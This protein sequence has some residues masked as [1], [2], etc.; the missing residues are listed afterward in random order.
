[1]TI[2]GELSHVNFKKQV[3]VSEKM[4]KNPALGGIGTLF[5]TIF[6]QKIINFKVFLLVVCIEKKSFSNL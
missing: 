2:W 1:M 5:I 4:K 3:S 6:F